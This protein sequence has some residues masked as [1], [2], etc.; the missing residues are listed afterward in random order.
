MFDRSEACPDVQRHVHLRSCAIAPRHDMMCALA[1]T[2]G[3]R[4]LARAACADCQCGGGAAARH[5]AA[6]SHPS[7][8]PIIRSSC[9]VTRRR[10]DLPLPPLHHAIRPPRP[11]RARRGSAACSVGRGQSC[12]VQH[13]GRREISRH[14]THPLLTAAHL[15]AVD[16]A[17][18]RKIFLV[19]FCCVA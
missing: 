12:R 4:G 8:Q 5:V 7:P 14:N 17:A 9:V 18:L 16:P 13:S 11:A 1:D 15:K 2:V 3:R 6:C 19:L 10:Q